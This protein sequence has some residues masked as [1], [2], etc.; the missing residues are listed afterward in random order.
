MKLYEIKDDILKLLDILDSELPA[1]IKDQAEEWLDKLDST[2]DEKAFNIARYIKN[3]EGESMAVK[4]EKDRL[5]KRQK[6]LDAKAKG[7][8]D[9]LSIMMNRLDKDKIKDDVFTIAMQNNPPSVDLVE[10]SKIPQE[11]WIE[12]EPV[13]DKKHLLADLKEEKEI[14]GCKLKV[15]RSV[16][17]R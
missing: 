12:Q 14:P 16:R 8:K 10:Q 6:A 1:E 17:I 3:L 13:L 9:Y 2:F 15:S 4:A 11:Y 7:L 5:A